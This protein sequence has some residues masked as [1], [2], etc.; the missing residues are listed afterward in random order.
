MHSAS[1]TVW[2][3]EATASE[4]DGDKSDDDEEYK[5]FDEQDL[6]TNSRK[7]EGCST[8]DSSVSF[9]L[10]FTVASFLNATLNVVHAKTKQRH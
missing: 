4:E 1:I 2:A 9:E 6:G 7:L 3:G 8:S 10:C 5:T